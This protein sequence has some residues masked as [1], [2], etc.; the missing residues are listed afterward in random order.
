MFDEEK[1]STILPAS[2]RE[3]IGALMKKMRYRKKVREDVREEIAAHFEDELRDC[4]TDEEKE[5]KAEQLV[6]EFGDLKLLAILLRRA[7]KRCRPLWRRLIA[8]T[9]HG[10][11]IL[12]MCFIFYVIW[13]ST[14]RPTIRMDYIALLNQLNQQPQ[15]RDKHNAWPH[16]K[17][18]I[19]L[20]VPPCPLVNEFISYREHGRDREEAILLKKAL[21]ENEPRVQA[22]LTKNQKYWDRLTAGQQRV[23]LKCLEYDWAPFPKTSSKSDTQW[24]ATTFRRMAEHILKCIQEGSELTLPHP[25]G[26]LPESVHPKFPNAELKM[27]LQRHRI[28]P[29]NLKAVSVAVLHEAIK[30]FKDLPEDTRAPLTDVESD[31][32][33]SWIAQNEPAW[34]QFLAG[35]EKGY[36]HRPYFYES[37]ARNKIAW[38]VDLQHLQSLRNLTKLGFWRSRLN[39]SH[40]RI[41]ESLEECLAIVRAGSH[42]KDKATLQ[43]QLFA[44]SINRTG[45][46]NILRI[47][48]A[49][50]LPAVDL[51]RLRHQ[52]SQIYPE[53]YPLMNLEGARLALLDIIQRSFTEG[54]PGG[55]HLIPTQWM[56]FSLTAPYEQL[57]AND[58]RLLLPLVTAKSMTHAG[59][60]ETIAMLNSRYDMER[61][62]AEMTPYQQ[63]TSNVQ[64]VKEMTESKARFA[65][66]FFLINFFTHNSHW[67]SEFFYWNKILYEATITILAVKQWRLEKNRYPDSLCELVSAGFLTE[68]PM[69]PWSDKPLGYKKTDDDF[70]LY[71]VGPNFTDDGGE[72][73]RDENGQIHFWLDN[74]DMVF[75]PQPKP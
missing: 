47:V 70:I 59:R 73:G 36:C 68:L 35:S 51:K 75:W 14:G 43:E 72:P 30:R 40:D 58:L 66:R 17:K 7:K 13:F 24:Y 44:Q 69:D 65:H 48:S 27:W 12:F 33:G 63:H 15:V 74:G 61:K 55:G 26:V 52:L 32:I 60:D 38:K 42:W 11:G 67:H 28:P 41:H 6:E 46:Q 39:E 45:C 16:Y 22:W 54:G 34:R 8:R 29:N 2:A 62:L 5:K 10:I 4:Q 53:G 25:R 64:T 57:D 20:Y 56:E 49:H 1:D 71:S 21:R 37:Q 19:D 50:S 18:A 23:F 31:V 9:C 3:Y